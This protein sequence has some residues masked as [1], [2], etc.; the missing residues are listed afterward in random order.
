MTEPEEGRAD[1]VALSRSQQNIYNG[2]LQDNDPALYLIGKSYRFH[3]LELSGFLAGLQATILNNPVQLCV[4]EAPPEGG[5]Y[6]ELAPRLQFGDIVR[7]R[8]DDEDHTDRGDDEF[9]RMWS[10]DIIA[11]PLVRYTVRTDRS[12]YVSG[13]DV[14]THHI[15]LD[16]GAT[17]IIETDLARH[18]A[19]EN[20]DEIPRVTNGLRKLAEAHRR[21]SA[22]VEESLQR[23][24]EIVR[25]ELADEARHGG[26]GQGS[27]D[28]PGTAAKG[29][30]HESARISGKAFDAILTLSEEKQVPLNVLVAAA[31][32]AVDAS[33]RQSTETLLV[34]A[35]DNRF[36]DADLNVATCLV[37]SV[38]QAVRFSPFA[39]VADVVRIV[40]RGYV[41]A[42]RRRWFREE[43]YRRMYLAINRTSNVDA[44]T[45][46]F[47]R[48]PCARGLRPFLSE[49]PVATDIGPV[50]GRTVACVL[51]EDQRAL[52]LAIWDRADLPERKTHPR[53]A[54]RIAAA[55]ESMTAMWHN[56]I[57]M[58]VN[59]WFGIG[60]DGALRQDDWATQTEQPAPAWFLNPARGVDLFLEIRCYVYPWVAWLVQNGAVPGDIL[61]F[62]DD[63]TDMTIDLL[64][65][66]H[67]AGC[68]YSVCDTV[69]ELHLRADAIAAHSDG[70]ST[71]VVNVAATGLAAVLDD[72][73]RKLV[74]GRIEKG[75]QDPLL[76]TKTAY[77]MPTSGTTG[78]PKLV[79]ISHGSLALF[80]DAVRRAYGWGPDDT[81]LQCAPLTSDISVEE[82]FGAAGCGSNLVRST[83]M[84]TGDL[85]ALA[86]DF[87]A[88][89]P[90]VIDLPT[91][92]WHLMCDDGDAIN[93][94]R[95]S[96][97]RQIVI[98]GEAIRPNA[99]DKWIE[100][101]A[102]QGISLVST[103]GPTETTVAVTYL[104]IVCD[105]TTVAGRDRLTLGRPLVPNTVFVAFG[106]VVIV[107]DLVSAGYLGIDSTSFGAVTATDGSRRRA[108]AT[109]DRVILD[110]N[111][112]R[113]HPAFSGRKDAIVKISG[114][115]V[116]T[117]E[118]VRR[119]FDDPAVSD[120]AVEP[121]KAGLGVWFETQRTREGAEDTAAAA[122]IRRILVRLGVPSFFVV[123]VPSIP[124][125]PNGKIDSGNLRTLPQFVDAVRNDAESG[126]KAAGLAEIWSRH[127]GR[128]IRSDSSLL[129]EGIGSLE[130]I[131]ILPET[132]RYL[133]RH[134]SLLDLI[135]ADSAANLAGSGST[136][137]GWMDVETAAAIERDLASLGRR[138]PL[139]GLSVK[140]SPTGRRSQ[141]IVVLGA[142]GI[143]GTG[144]A[145]AVLD[146]RRSGVPCPEVVLATRSQLPERDPWAALRS[147]DGVRIE[148]LSPQF[149]PD[150]LDALIRDTG[151][152]TLINCI[153][154]TNVLVPYRELRLANVELVSAITDACANRGTR[155][156]QLSTFVVNGAVSAPRVTDP[157]DAPY[158]YAA[159]KSLA[160]LVMAGSSPTVDFTIVRLPR[161]LGVDYQLRD[162]A[163]ILVSIVDACIALGAYPSVTL[164]EEV[165]T[166]RAAAKA[167]LGL[168]PELAGSAEL[169][170]GITVVRGA[171]VA[172]AEF[173]SGYALD[174]LD[175]EEWK[176]RL[177]KSAWATRNPRRWSVVD[178]WFGLGRRLG[179]RSYA[180]YLADGPTLALGVQSV[181][182]LDA[183][184]ESVRDV[185]AHGC[186]Q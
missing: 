141:A 129:D 158:P 144:F 148:R 124:R 177:D 147:V 152:R 178:A 186:S 184:P 125:K 179:T 133:H 85:Q 151:A 171:S 12:G 49:A 64:I 176:H 175:A 35:V 117:A 181:V 94:I 182:E 48:E 153:G 137:D 13:L 31:A 15:L 58:T 81:I 77:I 25:R 101:G 163:D 150:D 110:D 62:T 83:A 166:G 75:T 126:E 92:V 105:G 14:H 68:G 154:N 130:L 139:S 132:R 78:P 169:G 1:R 123:G 4:L 44:L 53:V 69:D 90:T 23:L 27:N 32:V 39:S 24:A 42:L 11:K 120:V 66:C 121:H 9:T 145:Q 5:D 180:E 73:L 156:V 56:P 71:H 122:R 108:F 46:N 7:V 91:A 59:E 112:D 80:S 102:S 16:G 128:A 119:I 70:I 84:K 54:Q 168:L 76:A 104:P 142:S 115:R 157:R 114:K 33:L 160:E 98:G 183:A 65:A 52:N 140:R 136:A 26:Y 61:V 19:A 51:D 6:P 37:N 111:L 86:Q 173:L 138:R 50:E 127:L 165:T 29:V 93:A 172:Y 38:A 107:G 164:T 22:K 170:R 8:S 60:P 161:I 74:D 113:G 143:L 89:G 82:I 18:L 57:A 55:L 103:Y 47:I 67:L 159:S 20:E 72:E 162:S 43:Q 185:L 131:R 149:G 30:L 36:G 40:D 41:M 146:L 96:R 118:A 3:P 34:H 116:D 167:I 17:G 10:P 109:A 99:V 45:L 2:V 95:R 106:E 63:N 100:S 88:K 155:L 79:G 28:A 97:L 174:E 87:V 135:S 134:L 21:E